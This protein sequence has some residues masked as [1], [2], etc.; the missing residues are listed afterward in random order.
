MITSYG[1]EL[2][3][4]QSVK[5]LAMGWKPSIQLPV[6]ANVFLFITLCSPLILLS[7]VYQW[8]FLQE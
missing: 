8:R 3:M 6:A 5:S 7:S 1:K 2:R 4:L